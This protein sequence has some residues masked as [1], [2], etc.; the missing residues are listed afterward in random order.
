[1]RLADPWF[2]AQ[3]YCDATA[4]GQ[5][6]ARENGSPIRSAEA[7]GLFLWCPCGVGAV[8]EHGAD[9]YPLD[10]SLNKGRPHGVLV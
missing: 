10:L 8:D 1:V 5:R 9:R 7:Q 6:I 4:S 3:F 2:E